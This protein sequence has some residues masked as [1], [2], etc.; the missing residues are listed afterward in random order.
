MNVGFVANVPERDGHHFF[1]YDTDPK[2]HP[3][4]GNG[5]HEGPAYG[6]HLPPGEKLALLEYL[7]TF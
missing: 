7:K 6:T 2:T 3:G 4:N 1:S 5:G